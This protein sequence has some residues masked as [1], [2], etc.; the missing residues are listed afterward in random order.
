MKTDTI[1]ADTYGFLNDLNACT[2]H[3]DPG[4]NGSTPSYTVRGPAGY[5]IGFNL[6]NAMEAAI[7]LRDFAI[8]FEQIVLACESDDHITFEQYVKNIRS[9]MPQAC[10][11][12]RKAKGQP[13]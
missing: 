4:H 10:A 5:K 7:E 9:I 6:T 12:N 11:A 13:I 8:A 1:N 3:H 2:F